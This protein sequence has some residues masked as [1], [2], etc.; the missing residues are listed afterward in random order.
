MVRDGILSW[1]QHK[2]RNNQPVEVTIPMLPELCS[3]IEA[4]PLSGLTRFSLR[5]MA[6]RSLPKA[7]LTR[8]RTGVTDDCSSDPRHHPRVT[9]E[10]A[11]QE[12]S[13]FRRSPPVS[14]EVGLFTDTCQQ[15][16]PFRT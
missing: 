3:I 13:W 6:V 7:S 12:P 14:R 2:G 4:T 8:W 1:V 9:N 16:S 10:G 11:H 15:R 5:H